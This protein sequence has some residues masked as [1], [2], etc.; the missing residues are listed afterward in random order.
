MAVTTGYWPSALG[1]G[2][3][4]IS[5]FTWLCDFCGD[6]GREKTEADVVVAMNLHATTGHP[7][8]EYTPTAVPE[9][10]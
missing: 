6:M 10:Q 1:P 5:A 4:G 9:E 7:D 3:F 2:G 8:E